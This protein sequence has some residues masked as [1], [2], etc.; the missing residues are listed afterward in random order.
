MGGVNHTPPLESELLSES[1]GEVVAVTV[2][3]VVGVVGDIEAVGG[4]AGGSGLMTWERA[5][6]TPES[7]GEEGV[8]LKGRF[9]A[10]SAGR[11]EERA[12]SEGTDGRRGLFLGSRLR[13]TQ[14]SSVDPSSMSLS[15]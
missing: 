2:L 14:S 13:R 10:L 1:L 15:W 4:M 11:V 8:R 7:W 3:G 5:A 6:Q 12:E 9:A